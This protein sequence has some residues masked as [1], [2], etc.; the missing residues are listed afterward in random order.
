[1]KM[2]QY[3]IN[4][5]M[6]MNDSEIEDIIEK[7]TKEFIKRLEKKLVGS[8]IKALGEE[9]DSIWSQN[10]KELT[11][12][13]TKVSA[14]YAWCSEKE[15]LVYS[16]LD[17]KLK[18]Y[19]ADKYGILYT[20]KKAEKSMKQLISQ[21]LGKSANISW[22]EQGM[23]GDKYVNFD[24]SIKSGLILPDYIKYQKTLKSKLPSIEDVWTKKLKI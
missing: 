23:Q 9:G 15:N 12:E 5:F 13:I 18:N 24:F 16:N 6:D 3:T 11:F 10:D 2:K 8:T 22:S 19:N 17:V 1:M 7:R 14:H 20:S 21:V 4:E